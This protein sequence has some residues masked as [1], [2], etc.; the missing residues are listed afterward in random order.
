[1]GIYGYCEPLWSLWVFL[2]V[3]ECHGCLWV[4]MRIYGC[5]WV[6]MGIYECLWI[7]MCIYG[8]LGLYGY[9]WVSM[10][11]WYLSISIWV[12]GC[13]WVP[14]GFRCLWIFTAVYGCLLGFR[15][16]WV[17]MGTYGWHEGLWVLYL[18]IENISY[19]IIQEPQKIWKFQK[20]SEITHVLWKI[21]YA[22]RRRETLST[23]VFSVLI[24]K[25]PFLPLG[26]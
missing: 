12:H 7:F 16:F 1:M 15:G 18:N 13:L 26:A 14:I 8:F 4:S 9:L 17:S 20:T 19:F 10:G 5:L 11:L 25:V 22:P 24:N 21:A 2:S 3:Y 23:R 6:L